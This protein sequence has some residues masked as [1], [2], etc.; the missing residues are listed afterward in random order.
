MNTLNKRNNKVSSHREKRWDG[1]YILSSFFLSTWPMMLYGIIYFSLGLFPRFMTIDVQGIYELERTLFGI[2]ADGMTGIDGNATLTYAEYFTTHN[3][4]WADI[5]SG[6]CY[7]CWVP[8]PCLFTL[9]LYFKGMHRHCLCFTLTFLIMN[10][11]GYMIWYIHPTAAPW[12]VMQY[13]FDVVPDA[14]SCA[15]GLLRFDALTGTRLFESIYKSSTNVFGAF[16]SLHAAKMSMVCL[17]S[18]LIFEK[19]KRPSLFV[20]AVLSLAITLGTWFAA[21]YTSHHYI[22]DV[23][24]GIGLVGIAYLIFAYAVRPLRPFRWMNDRLNNSW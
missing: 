15:A 19:D 10:I 9:F 12:Y 3:W 4:P 2:T 5:L 1:T 8:V 24:A 20:W 22:L 14:P 23:L 16:P 11:V 7:I 21:I 17:Y 13:G 18:V 6:I